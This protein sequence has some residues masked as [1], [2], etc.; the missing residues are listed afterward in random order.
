[1]KWP[2]YFALD[3]DPADEARKRAALD[4]EP[5]IVDDRRAAVVEAVPVMLQAL[6]DIHFDDGRTRRH[7]VK[8]ERVPADDEIVRRIP[9]SFGLATDHDHR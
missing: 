2:Q 8:G 5:P 9:A 3:G 7:F 6:D 4:R 1:M